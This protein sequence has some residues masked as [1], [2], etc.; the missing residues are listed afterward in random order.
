MKILIVEDEKELVSSVKSYLEEDGCI[1]D[2]ALEFNDADAMNNLYQ[3]DCVVVDITLPDGSALDI[4]K[5]LKKIGSKAG[6]VIISAKDSLD[7]KLNGLDIG[8]EDY[9]SLKS[10]IIIKIMNIF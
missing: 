5:N 1:C 2:S 4:V 10:I 7:D 9:M 8:A 3:Y 6:I